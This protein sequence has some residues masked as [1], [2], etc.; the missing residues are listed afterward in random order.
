MLLLLS[1]WAFALTAQTTDG[2][3]WVGTGPGHYSTTQ[4]A[5]DAAG[6]GGRVEIS[7]G[8]SEVLAA[9]LTL[10]QANQTVHFN[11]CTSQITQGAFQVL[12]TADNV[13]I[14]SDCPVPLADFGSAAG[15]GFVGYT[16]RGVAMQIGSALSDLGRYHEQGILHSCYGTCGTGATLLKV[17]RVEN[18]IIERPG[19]SLH[20]VNVNKGIVFDGTGTSA[21]VGGVIGSMN[22]VGTG[23]NGGSI[24]LEL[25]NLAVGTNVTG[26]FIG[27]GTAR[28]NIGVYVTGTATSINFHGLQMDS[29]STCL[30]VD[31][32]GSSPQMWGDVRFDSTCAANTC[33]NFT[34]TT[35]ANYLVTNVSGST[36]LTDNGTNNSIV[37]PT[38]SSWND[39]L[40]Q[41]RSS[42]SQWSLVDQQSG[43]VS[44]LTLSH[45]SNSF[46]IFAGSI[47]MNSKNGSFIWQNNG[48]TKFNIDGS[49]N[50]FPQTG[51][52]GCSGE[53]RKRLVFRLHW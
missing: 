3:A 41:Y 9:N 14:L 28:G 29:A 18:P 46:F 31:S 11:G 51:G 22:C 53:K 36:C 39:R 52:G 21:F 5:V 19:I 15:S 25:G 48:I 26:G 42:R 47:F 44:S 35:N 33:V 40:W 2:N 7:S 13:S 4:A 37:Q 6:A 32:T 49:G 16:G 8:W 24:C 38:V 43:G 30:K 34:E 1:G 27:L 12:V 10:K 17:L 20:A 50:I 45:A 23:S